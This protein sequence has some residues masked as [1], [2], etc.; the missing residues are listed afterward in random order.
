MNYLSLTSEQLWQCL[1]NVDGELKLLDLL[2]KSDLSY[3]HQHESLMEKRGLIIQTF[4]DAWGYN[5]DN[6][7]VSK[8]PTLE[9]RLKD[10]LDATKRKNAKELAYFFKQAL[11]EI[12]P[13]LEK[14]Y[15]ALQE[16][17]ALEGKQS[18]LDE[19]FGN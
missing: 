4:V 18:L 2:D 17:K 19:L 6:L 7:C 12:D 5:P 16:L 11:E 13:R 15:N 1:R 9:D 3:N 10:M 14:Y 8:K